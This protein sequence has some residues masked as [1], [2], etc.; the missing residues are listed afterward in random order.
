VEQVDKKDL[1]Q[2]QL[3]V[4]LKKQFYKTQTWQFVLYLLV[5]LVPFVLLSLWGFADVHVA[6]RIGAYAILGVTLV[7]C[8]A[9]VVQRR[10]R[11]T[12]EAMRAL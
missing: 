9:W 1:T 7:S 11:K 10:I 2:E 6:I 4:V 3:E 12:I 8:E 5:I